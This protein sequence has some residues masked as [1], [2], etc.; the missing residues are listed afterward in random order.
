MCMTKHYPFLV[1]NTIQLN[2]LLSYK[3]GTYYKFFLIVRAKDKLSYS[4]SISLMG[5]E[6]I[7]KYWLVRNEDDYKKYIKEMNF[8]CS[9]LPGSRLYFCLDRK[10]IKKTLRLLRNEVID[11]LDSDNIQR[12]LFE[13]SVTS[14][15]FSSDRTGLKYLLDIDYDVGNGPNATFEQVSER[16][17]DFMDKLNKLI[18]DLKQNGVNIDIVE[19]STKNGKHLILPRNFNPQDLKDL[20]DRY[21]VDLKTNA[22]TLILMSNTK[23]TK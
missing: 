9:L 8:L 20:C 2:K 18:K 14:K 17:S 23:M 22:A 16:I 15:D 19:C 4:D 5:G 7:I 12:I 21:Y 3:E 13:S 11:E 10:D 1:D 6:K